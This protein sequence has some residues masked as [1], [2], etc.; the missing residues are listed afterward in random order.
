V[1]TAFRII[2]YAINN[3]H[4]AFEA[5]SMFVFTNNT[6]VASTASQDIAG[7]AWQSG[8]IPHKRVLTSGAEKAGV[9]IHARLVAHGR[10]RRSY[11]ICN[12][13]KHTE[14]SSSRK[15]VHRFAKAVAI[16]HHPGYESCN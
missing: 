13:S 7:T 1:L 15:I 16:M 9:A 12:I 5:R 3:P 4:I 10:G 2:L 14:A 8:S 11:V 6:Q